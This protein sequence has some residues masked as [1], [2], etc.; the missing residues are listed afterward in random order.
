MS[1]GLGLLDVTTVS[2]VGGP[3]YVPL[4][5]SLSPRGL[6]GPQQSW[7]RPPPYL[8]MSCKAVS[9]G[10]TW[11]WMPCL[12]H[13]DF[14]SGATLYKL[15]RGMVGKRLQRVGGGHSVRTPPLSA[16]R[17]CPRPRETLSAALPVCPLG[18]LA[19]GRGTLRG[20][21]IDMDRRVRA[22]ETGKTFS[23]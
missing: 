5:L 20:G 19:R 10:F 17:G 11:Y 3:G 15:C 9:R 22:L 8:T 18:W 4:D 23:G 6:E 1:A 2:T 7:A 21:G 16:R 12:A 14:T 13:R